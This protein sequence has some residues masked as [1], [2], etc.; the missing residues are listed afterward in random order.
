MFHVSTPAGSLVLARW[1][2]FRTRSE[3]EAFRDAIKA[4][5]T[6]VRP[7][8]ICADW[9]SASIVSPDVSEVM[10][11]MLRAANPMLTRSAI[12]LA[13]EHA[14]FNLQTERLVREAGNPHR[15]TFRVAADM[16]A[17]L[18]EVLTA[19]EH[20][21]ARRFVSEGDASAAIAQRR[22]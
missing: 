6:K 1:S 21:A 15:R 13:S 2:D 10:S 19:D 16:L 22:A 20:E 5:V 9:R 17:W 7:A 11:S 3:A 8:I 4:A 18:G 12:L 14:T